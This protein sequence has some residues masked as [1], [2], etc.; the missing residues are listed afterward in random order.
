M[1]PL[2]LRRFRQIS[3][4]LAVGIL[5]FYC[6]VAHVPAGLGQTDEVGQEIAALKDANPQVRW[7]AAK[8]LGRSKDPCAVDPLIA[9]LKNTGDTPL[10]TN[11]AVALGEIKDPRVVEPLIEALESSEDGVRWAAFHALGEIKDPRAVGPMMALENDPYRYATFSV[12]VLEDFGT[13][14]VEPLIVPLR[15]SP[16][17]PWSSAGDVL[18]S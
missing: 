7:D 16:F 5:P 8:A 9:A 1:S 6:G 4:W 18:G 13:S 14:A 3:R 11:A 10:R 15:A 12:R 2:K 17:F